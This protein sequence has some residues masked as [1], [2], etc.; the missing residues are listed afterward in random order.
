M[1]DQLEGQM[2]IFDLDTW[3]GK[4]CQE[5]STATKEKTSKPSSRKSSGSLTKN[6]PMCLCLRSGHT[7]DASTMNWEDGQLLGAYTMRSFGESPREENASRLS[8]I[9]EDYPLP[10]YSLSARACQGIL[11]RAN[12]RGKKLPEQLE[13]ALMNQATLLRSEE[14]SNVTPTENEQEKEL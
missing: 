10:K 5:H 13:K 7:Q 2:S 6:A 9:L 14:E 4:T 12:R 1:T 11:N 3:S 8:Q